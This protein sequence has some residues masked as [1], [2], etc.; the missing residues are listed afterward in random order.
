MALKSGAGEVL[1]SGQHR[2][3]THEAIFIPL[4]PITVFPVNPKSVIEEKTRRN[5]LTA[6][7]SDSFLAALPTGPAETG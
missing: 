2:P 1:L 6:F 7:F 3:I 4:R 5:E